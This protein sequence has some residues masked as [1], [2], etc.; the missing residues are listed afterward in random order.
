MN[1]KKL[2]GLAVIVVYLMVGCMSTSNEMPAEAEVV[3]GPAPQIVVAAN[4]TDR[5]LELLADKNVAVVGNHTT[6]IFKDGNGESHTH[7]VDSLLS[8]GIRITQ[9]FA[10]EHGFRGDADAGEK[11]AD[12]RDPQTNLPVISLYGSN[13]KPS[14]EQLEGVDVVLFDIQDV[15]VRFYTYLSTMHYV[16]ESCAENGIPVVVLDRP[17]P[18]GHYVDGPLVEPGYETFVGLHPVPVVYGMTIGEYAKM[19][20]GEKWLKDQVQCDLTVIPLE[21]YTH[22]SDY[23]LPLRP[24]PNLPN[25]KSINLY[26]SLCLFEGTNVNVG[27]G[28]DKQFQVFGSPDLPSESYDYSFVPQPNFGAK[29]PKHQGKT[30]YGLDLSQTPD[31]SSLNFSWVIEAYQQTADQENFFRHPK[32]FDRLAGSAKLREQIVE[33]K[34]LSEIQANWAEGLSSFKEIRK[35]YQMY[36]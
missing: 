22:E 28:T 29:T 36:P 17:N 9:V 6:V 30:C 33:G 13:F 21:G 15:G 23:S 8:L 20:N 26:S 14:P 18:N 7:L 4:Q 27:R 1:Y 31:L 11:I 34:P 5:Y 16:M 24:S 32:H 10:P 12:S 25:D 3:E 35:K 2:T 19:I